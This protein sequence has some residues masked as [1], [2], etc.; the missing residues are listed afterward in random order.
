MIETIQLKIV[1]PR[2]SAPGVDDLLTGLRSIDAMLDKLE[3]RKPIVLQGLAQASGQVNQLSDYTKVLI[4]RLDSIGQRGEMEKLRNGFRGSAEEVQHLTGLIRTMEGNLA[5]LDVPGARANP[6]VY[7]KISGIEGAIAAANLRLNQIGTVNTDVSVR[8]NFDRDARGTMET[9]GALTQAA[10]ESTAALRTQTDAVGVKAAEMQK[11]TGSLAATTAGEEAETVAI[12]E[13]A[14]ISE[15]YISVKGEMS[16]LDAT[17]REGVGITRRELGASDEQ[18]IRSINYLEQYKQRFADIRREGSIAKSNFPTRSTEHISAITNE[19][20]ATAAELQ[21]MRAAG[22]GNETLFQ[23]QAQREALLR[24]QAARIEQQLPVLGPPAKDFER[25]QARQQTAAAALQRQRSAAYLRQQREAERE[26]QRLAE[27]QAA[28]AEGQ[29]AV[30]RFNQLS[31]GFAPQRS[32]RR[33]LPG[34]GYEETTQLEK[35]ANGLRQSIQLRA[36]YDSAGRLM[37]GGLKETSQTMENYNRT[38]QR[39]LLGTIG[40]AAKFILI[41]QGL[42]AVIRAFRTG[43]EAAVEYERKLAAL[44]AIFRGNREEAQSLARQSL[45]IA[46]AYGQDGIAALQVATDFA[47][48][49]RDARDTAEAVRAVALAANVAGISMEEASHSIQGIVDSFATPFTSLNAVVG[50]LN[51]IATTTNVTMKQLLDGLARVGPLAKATG[52]SLGE[53]VG[54]EAA[55]SG[56]TGR[57]GSEAGNAIKTLLSRLNRPATQQQLFDFGVNTLGKGGEA[58]TSSEVIN[59]LFV[60]YERLGKAEQQEL[61]VRVAGAQQAARIAALFDGYIQSQRLAIRF[62]QDQTNADRQNILVMQTLSAHLGTLKTRWEQFWV[63]GSGAAGDVGIRGALSDV[64]KLAS[65]VLQGLTLLERAASRVA[66]LAQQPVDAL[67]NRLPGD[68]LG[69]VARRNAN[70]VHMLGNLLHPWSFVTDSFDQLSENTSKLQE[71]GHLL[72]LI[73]EAERAAQAVRKLNAEVNRL[74]GA[75]ESEEFQGRIFRTLGR[76]AQT[77]PLDQLKKFTQQGGNSELIDLANAGRR[78]ELERR[79]NQLAEESGRK[80]L[81]NRKTLDAALDQGIARQEQRVT[82]TQ[83]GGSEKEIEDAQRELLRLQNLRQG[84][85]DRDAQT[86][87]EQVEADI[88]AREEYKGRLLKQAQAQTQLLTG[89]RPSVNPLA[90]HVEELDREA[91]GLRLVTD[92]QKQQIELDVELGHRTRESADLAIRGITE[93]YE[94]D[95][96][97]LEQRR[98]FAALADAMKEGGRRGAIEPEAFRIGQNET[99]QAFNE[100]AGIQLLLGRA[101]DRFLNAGARGDTRGAASAQAE[102][103]ELVNRLANDALTVDERRFRLAGEIVNLRRREAEEASRNLQLASREEQL[104]AALVARFVQQRGGRGF[105]TNEFQFLD[106][107]TRQSI[108]RF[109]PNALPSTISTPRRQ[110]ERELTEANA[111]FGSLRAMA[112]EARNALHST[113]GNR[114]IAPPAGQVT[115]PGGQPATAPGVQPPPINLE[116]S[117]EFRQM[118]AVMETAV[119]GPLQNE[120]ND[121]RAQVSAFLSSQ[122]VNSAQSGASVAA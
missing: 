51:A 61:L 60:G 2:I 13:N 46:A 23:Q 57:P 118:I 102:A 107:G 28:A 66:A 64:V 20:D 105:N 78:L 26:A 58:R 111:M 24:T 99:E 15:R 14:A 17:F 84:N 116:F 62:S 44:Q 95:R 41:Y 85:R 92:L 98:E 96:R 48:F 36:Q 52:L 7:N 76:I 39:T 65:D 108:E 19:A 119:R 93:Q 101:R 69:P 113:F 81:D 83:K 45:E 110:A 97:L 25:E 120:I 70:P 30:T 106:Q 112:E 91:E 49:G 18:F 12:G 33:T 32:Q 3:S 87:A 34:G 59:E 88:S 103:Q 72:F 82:K 42:D 37:S 6:A 54:I 16:R 86:E 114:L 47:R 89:A 10:S 40:M 77:A 8:K 43:G 56:R 21:R 11:L 80:Q 53:T 63:A 35:E 94:A 27:E 38:T 90:Q 75:T 29:A 22:L 109:N 5:R 121:M 100:S 117:G 71:K 55:I 67:I 122:R 115:A 50:G 73:P 68:Q 79:A 9:E 4:D 31:P 1:T 104:R 74:V